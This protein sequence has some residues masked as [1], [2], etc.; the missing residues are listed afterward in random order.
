MA[1]NSIKGILKN[2]MVGHGNTTTSSIPDKGQIIFDTYGTDFKVGSDLLTT[3]YNNLPSFLSN[4][5][6]LFKVEDNNGSSQYLCSWQEDKKEYRLLLCSDTPA[7]DI[8]FLSLSL[9]ESYGWESMNHEKYLFV[10]NLGKNDLTI[11]FSN[12]LHGGKYHPYDFIAK[13]ENSIIVPSGDYGVEI[14][15]IGICAKDEWHAIITVSEV[16]KVRNNIY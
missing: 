7:I 9:A 2:A 12:P 15:F 14:G 16:L 10:F 5:N 6:F 8:T 4:T 3:T 11:T 1:N 13:P